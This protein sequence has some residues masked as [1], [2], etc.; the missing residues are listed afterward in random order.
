MN[1]IKIILTFLRITSLLFLHLTAD[2]QSI[3][4]LEDGKQQ[5]DKIHS[6]QH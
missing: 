6:M 2:V 3:C 4:K 5:T 1:T